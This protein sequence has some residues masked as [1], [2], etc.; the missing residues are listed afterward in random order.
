[1]CGLVRQK[2]RVGFGFSR[3]I[4]S[5]R[6][7][8]SICWVRARK[9][10]VGSFSTCAC[11]NTIHHAPAK[12]RQQG[13]KTHTIPTIRV[14]LLERKQTR[15]NI[16]I[17]PHHGRPQNIAYNMQILGMRSGLR[18]PSPPQAVSF[19]YEYSPAL[20]RHLKLTVP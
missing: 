17:F 11:A 7:K 10:H 6:D 18:P 9:V 20:S 14:Q 2:K 1:M 19:E 13:G 15:R 12:K 16:T 8:I 5:R 4:C 3:E